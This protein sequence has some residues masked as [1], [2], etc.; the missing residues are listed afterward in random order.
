MEQHPEQEVIIPLLEDKGVIDA[1]RWAATSSLAGALRSFDE[2]AGN[3]ANVL[4]TL[5]H[6]QFHNRIDRAGSTGD[7][8]VPEGESTSS[9][10]DILFSGLSDTEI[11]TFPPLPKGTLV[12]EDYNQSPAW[13]CEKA[14]IFI[15]SVNPG[16]FENFP[17]H[18][19]KSKTKREIAMKP[20]ESNTVSFAQQGT[21]P[22][23]LPEVESIPDDEYINLVLVHSYD[24]VTM[25]QEIALGRPRSTK[26][27]EPQWH[28]LEPISLKS[29]SPII[30]SKDKEK[31]VAVPDPAED[32]AVRLRKTS[33]KKSVNQDEK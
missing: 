28:W 21:L 10:S 7:Y 32:V 29:T 15:Q 25:R 33:Q 13:I 12:R 1:F 16:Q 22:L 19:Q 3:D 18:S 30:G 6:N 4:G 26:E 31:K 27:K 24:P 20:F 5:R 11:S 8:A 17:W 14:R 9:G 23:D 2:E